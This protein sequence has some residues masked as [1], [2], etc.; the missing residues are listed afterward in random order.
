MPNSIIGSKPSK[1]RLIGKDAAKKKGCETM[2]NFSAMTDDELN[3]AIFKA[4]GWVKLSFPAFP[5]WQRPIRAGEVDE[6]G[7]GM[8]VWYELV[9]DYT[10]DWR[11]CGELITEMGDAISDGWELSCEHS[12]MDGLDPLKWRVWMTRFTNDPA[13]F[14]SVCGEADNPIRAFDNCWLAWKEQ[15]NGT[16]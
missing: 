14:R 13:D 8:T 4:K 6:F 10:H 12:D 1:R 15:E 11:L 5:K 16:H 3:E 7:K 9:P 2:T